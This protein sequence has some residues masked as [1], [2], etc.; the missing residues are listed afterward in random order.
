M[1]R[2][3]F[4]SVMLLY[5][6]TTRSCWSLIILKDDSPASDTDNSPWTDK[7]VLSSILTSKGGVVDGEGVRLVYPPGA[8]D[9]PVNVN[10]T[11]EDPSKYEGFLFRKDLEN[12]YLHVLYSISTRNIVIHRKDPT[13][14]R[15]I[16][17]CNS[18][19]SYN[20]TLASNK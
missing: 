8:V 1:V 11:F 18:Q 10:V 9:S 7:N 3:A 14:Y 12:A 6:S 15:S 16:N 19:T 13:T 17:A 5:C 20:L 2:R 4:I